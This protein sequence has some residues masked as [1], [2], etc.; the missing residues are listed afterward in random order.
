MIKLERINKYYHM[1]T[2]IVHAVSN[3]DL[4]IKEGEFV[5]LVG[6]SGS[7]KSTMMHIIG[8]LDTP[9]SG[10]VI[11][12]GQNL[13]RASDKALSRYRNRKVGFV[14]QTFNL[15]PTYNAIDNVALPLIFSK[16][17]RKKR[18]KLAEEALETVGL[19]G[20]ALHR[21]NQLSGGE[22]QRVS[23]ARA[24]VTQPRLILADEPTGNLD[25][26]NGEH[27]ME[28]LSRL[29]REKGITLVVV[30]HDME[31]AQIAARIIKMRDGH[32]L[33]DTNG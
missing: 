9:T 3:V 27:I 26:K 5:A 17:R 14:F 32:I 10:R 1:G 21:P 15:H 2:E 28:L 22:R 29:N 23:I 30:T 7:G 31:M 12:D 33:E 18:M 19:P 13:S 20:R 4:E 8:G 6:P 16:I 25:R 11:V 24:I